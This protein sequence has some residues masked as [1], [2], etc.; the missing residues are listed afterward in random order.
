MGCAPAGCGYVDTAL[1]Y[2]WRFWGTSVGPRS[3]DFTHI[4]PEVLY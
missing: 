2:Y 4:Y 3:N 1:A